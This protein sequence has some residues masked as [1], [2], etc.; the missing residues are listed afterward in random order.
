M[1]S[2]FVIRIICGIIGGTYVARALFALIRPVIAAHT[3][4]LDF[5]REVGAVEYLATFGAMRF[6]IGSFL[7]VG[8]LSD[9]FLIASL[10]LACMVS[11]ATLLCRLWAS[12]YAIGNDDPIGWL[13]I[14]GDAFVALLA[15]GGL[16]A[17]TASPALDTL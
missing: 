10:V 6:A 7:L 15:Y 4:G 17:S 1:L 9:E 14:A 16:I 11:T 8:S 2:T 13:G 3:R 12:R 5:E